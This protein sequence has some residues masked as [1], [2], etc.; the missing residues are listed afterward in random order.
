[1]ILK[2]MEAVLY[3]AV[4][5]VLAPISDTLPCGTGLLILW[6]QYSEYFL[7]NLSWCYLGWLNK[8][9]TLAYTLAIVCWHYAIHSGLRGQHSTSLDT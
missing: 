3:V 7:L 9:Y 1:M 2:A 6:L 4:F 8:L 5:W